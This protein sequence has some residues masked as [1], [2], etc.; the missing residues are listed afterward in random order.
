MKKILFMLFLGVQALS[1]NENQ[2]IQT[3]TSFKKNIELI[4]SIEKFNE[5]GLYYFVLEGYST[6]R[7]PFGMVESGER[8]V[9]RVHNGFKT[10]TTGKKEYKTKDGQ[11]H[12]EAIQ[13]TGH[14]FINPEGKNQIIY[15]SSSGANSSGFLIEDNG[16]T[17]T[18]EMEGYSDLVGKNVKSKWVKTKTDK[19]YNTVV[20][21]LIDG[22]WQELRKGEYTKI[23]K[24]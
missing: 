9:E 11:L 23:E 24:K 4:N 8:K 14:S 1:A 22:K 21:Y 7:Y 10:Y 17:Q 20:Y 12:I 3:N 2:P 6:D 19:G 18:I 16:K 13:N 15:V 5:P